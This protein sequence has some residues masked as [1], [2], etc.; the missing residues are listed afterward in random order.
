MPLPYTLSQIQTIDQKND[1]LKPKV[2]FHSNANEYSLVMKTKDKHITLQLLEIKDL[3]NMCA[4]H[5]NK[6]LCI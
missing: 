2:N 6:S 3:N 1:P 4:V 5:G